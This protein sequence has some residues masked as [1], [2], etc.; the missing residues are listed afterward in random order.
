MLDLGKHT[1]VELGAEVL[2]GRQS[3]N[4]SGLSPQA[5]PGSPRVKAL[6]LHSVPTERHASDNILAEVS[7]QGPCLGSHW[8]PSLEAPLGAQ[9][10][11]G[12]MCRPLC[13]S[14][15]PRGSSR[16]Q[17]WRLRGLAG[18][19]GGPDA[20][21]AGRRAGVAA[22][23][24]VPGQ[25]VTELGAEPGG[26]TLG[27]HFPTGVSSVGRGCTLLHTLLRP[28]RVPQCLGA[29]EN[30]VLPPQDCRAE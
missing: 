20:E 27:D 18:S 28:G 26:A 10:A 24:P 14:C 7:S 13:L 29:G 22:Q 11:W 23:E 4:K 19:A 3:H 9:A 1:H 21:Q 25:E 12:G 16:V 15:Q 17:A 5:N 8:V 2:A 30:G 6:L